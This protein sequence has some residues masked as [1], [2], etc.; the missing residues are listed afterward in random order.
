MSNGCLRSP[1]KFT[2]KSVYTDLAPNCML[3]D[4]DNK[5]YN[6]STLSINLGS[7]YKDDCESPLLVG[8]GIIGTRIWAGGAR[9]IYNGNLLGQYSVDQEDGNII[10]K[11]RDQGTWDYLNFF[12][13]PAWT[14]VITKIIERPAGCPEPNP[15][16]GSCLARERGQEENKAHYDEVAYADSINEE[17]GSYYRYYESPLEVSQDFLPLL[18]NLNNAGENECGSYKYKLSEAGNNPYCEEIKGDRQD[19]APGCPEYPNAGEGSGSASSNERSA[20]LEYKSTWSYEDLAKLVHQ[21]LDIK[22]ARASFNIDGVVLAS[23]YVNGSTFSFPRFRGLY[24]P[25]SPTSLYNNEIG[26]LYGQRVGFQLQYPNFKKEELKGI[27][28][29]VYFF[30]HNIEPVVFSDGTTPC[31]CG[32]FTGEIREKIPFEITSEN[33]IDLATFDN[34]KDFPNGTKRPQDIPGYP[35]AEGQG[36]VHACYKI[37]K[38]SYK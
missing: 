16:C 25:E 37:T 24:N 35:D 3:L 7:H 36:G 14:A 33:P 27:N 11:A 9:Y 28:G 32:D 2:K 5:C 31:G 6:T 22:W 1:L 15:T 23:N 17:R 29:E 26:Y 21:S 10:F 34:I 30:S 4:C 18:F 19:P 8:G 20:S 12:N 13:R 38:V